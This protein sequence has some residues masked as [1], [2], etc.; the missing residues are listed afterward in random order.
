MY[1]TDAPK[2][3]KIKVHG[4]FVKLQYLIT[5]PNNTQ[6]GIVGCSKTMI[7]KQRVPG[8]SPAWK[9]KEFFQPCCDP[10]LIGN[11]WPG[12]RVT[13]MQLMGFRSLTTWWWV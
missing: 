10:Q 7:E 4:Q 12:T 9:R 6:A 11:S 8:S 3:L 2:I 13:W 5:V 1:E